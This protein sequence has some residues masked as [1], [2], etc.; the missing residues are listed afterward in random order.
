MSTD[1][2]L[3][4]QSV[5]EP[6]D[7]GP[8]RITPPIGPDYWSYRV[9]LTEDQAL[10][11]FPKFGTI[12]VGFAREEDWNTNLPFWVPADT[13]WEHIKH[14]AGDRTITMD[15]VAE[16]LGLIFDAVRADHPDMYVGV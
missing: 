6:G 7:L 14:N 16:A 4:R 3:E 15:Q 2:T 1:L 8:I 13:L 11:G 10:L 9:K 12:G 5:T